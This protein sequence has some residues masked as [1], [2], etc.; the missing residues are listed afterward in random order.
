VVQYGDGLQG[1]VGVQRDG[2]KPRDIA[3]HLL[4]LLRKRRMVTAPGAPTP[5]PVCSSVLLGAG[6]YIPIASQEKF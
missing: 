2:P 6:A 1:E 3:L 5:T 4:L